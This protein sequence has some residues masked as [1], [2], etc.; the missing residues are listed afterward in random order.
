[1]SWKVAIGGTQFAE[2][3]FQHQEMFAFFVGHFHPVICKRCRQ[4][5][6]AITSE[7]GK[8]IAGQINRIEFYMGKGMKKGGAPGQTAWSTTFHGAGREQLRFAWASRTVWHIDLYARPLQFAAAPVGSHLADRQRLLRRIGS[9]QHS[10][11][12]GGEAKS[13]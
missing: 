12:L 11:C 3:R 5:G 13:G 10:D 6:I 9:H 8:Q 7:P 2:P 1:M 4:G